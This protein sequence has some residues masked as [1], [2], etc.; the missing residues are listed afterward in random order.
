MANPPYTIA[1]TGD[2]NNTDLILSSESST[3]ADNLDDVAVLEQI[4]DLSSANGVVVGRLNVIETNITALTSGTSL[5]STKITGLTGDVSLNLADIK[6]IQS[7]IS[8]STS[9][10]VT[11]S[12]DL[13][14]RGKIVEYSGLTTFPDYWS[15]MWEGGIGIIF[16]LVREKD[17]TYSLWQP[18]AANPYN[19]FKLPYVKNPSVFKPTLD[20]CGN[21]TILD[22]QSLYGYQF[23]LKSFFSKTSSDD[24]IAMAI[25]PAINQ[26]ESYLLQNG[27]NGFNIF[28][29]KTMSPGDSYTST[30][31]QKFL[32]EYNRQAGELLMKRAFNLDTIMDLKNTWQELGNQLNQSNTGQKT[33][34]FIG[35]E[36]K[37]QA[38]MNQKSFIEWSTLHDKLAT[39]TIDYNYTIRDISNQTSVNLETDGKFI[40][41][42]YN[43]RKANEQNKITVFDHVKISDTNNPE[44]DK[45]PYFKVT[46]YFYGGYSNAIFGAQIDERCFQVALRSPLNISGGTLNFRQ[47]DKY[48]RDNSYNITV[49]GG[50]TY[51]TQLADDITELLSLQG[52]ELRV[53][54]YNDL[55]LNLSYASSNKQDIPRYALLSDSSNAITVTAGLDLNSQTLLTTV[56]D[57]SVITRDSSGVPLTN[58]GQKYFLHRG[59][60]KILQ[61]SPLLVNGISGGT[62]SVTHGNATT[63]SSPRNYYA[64][65]ADIV[66]E[67][68]QEE[69]TLWKLKIAY[70][71]NGDPYVPETWNNYQLWLDDKSNLSQLVRSEV[72]GSQ[73]AG[74]FGIYTNQLN[75]PAMEFLS[76]VSAPPGESYNRYEYRTNRFLSPYKNILNISDASAIYNAG[77]YTFQNY[78]D[79][80]FRLAKET[81]YADVSGVRGS[82]LIMRP[83]KDNLFNSLVDIYS[84]AKQVDV[85]LV[86]LNGVVYSGTKV[87]REVTATNEHRFGIMKQSIV[88]KLLPQDASNTKV[89]Y[90]FC[91]NMDFANS[92]YTSDFTY[93][94][95]QDGLSI[96]MN[97]YFQAFGVKLVVTDVRGNTG[98]FGTRQYCPFGPNKVATTIQTLFVYQEGTSALREQN[99]LEVRELMRDVLQKPKNYSQ[100]IKSF[101]NI[102]LSEFPDGSNNLTRQINAGHDSIMTNTQFYNGPSGEGINVAYL[103]SDTSISAPRFLQIEISNFRDNSGRFVDLS[104]LAT[105]N[106]VFVG[107]TPTALGSGGFYPPRSKHVLVATDP[108]TNYMNN[109][110]LND[111]VAQVADRQQN[112]IYA[113]DD[114]EIDDKIGECYRQDAITDHTWDTFLIEIGKKTHPKISGVDFNDKT[115]WRDLRLEKA[116]KC[117]YLGKPK[118]DAL[119]QRYGKLLSDVYLD[120]LF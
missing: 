98:G 10:V 7:G 4:H 46:R 13:F 102:K 87:W 27:N 110:I 26:S 104:G 85:S 38:N 115:T 120:K 112:Q 117:A 62:I 14:V 68:C 41:V 100:A 66:F 52:C 51:P 58:A 78:L 54:F 16:I 23:Q 29:L 55:D 103:T 3:I 72:A 82:S 114:Q 40:I 108:N 32:E 49:P 95:N 116:V 96:V 22:L 25:S 101:V 15:G 106:I 18:S 28:L 77:G 60:T 36:R 8:V 90:Y 76:G 69:H 71:L 94:Y 99:I 1:I 47:R 31:P 12:N 44:L 56:L 75:S 39:S 97:N 43:F 6:T 37:I 89:G 20:A 9:A 19:T 70:D 48:G 53:L 61:F 24:K 88:A 33:L 45:I 5:N 84:V 64:T 105:G 80:T 34:K 109:T 17:L 119:G 83:I 21:Y 113:I 74:S 42:K 118:L 107:T 93:P 50:Y 11:I 92:G 79:T 111:A 57:L 2:N 73:S 67:S 59:G 81:I 65:V 63:T 30:D 86:D 91:A 35:T